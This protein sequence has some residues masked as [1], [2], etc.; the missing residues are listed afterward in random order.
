MKALITGIAGFAGSHL[1]EYLL[2]IG[3]EVS[4]IVRPGGRLDNISHLLGS[5]TLFPADVNDQE[6]VERAIMQSAP[7]YLFHLAAQSDVHRSWKEPLAT[8]LNNVAGQ[9]HLL[10]AIRL[11]RP[12]C[13][14]LIA[15]SSE[16]YG[17]VAPADVPIRESQPLRPVNPYAVSKTA[18]DLFGY[19]YYK[20]YGLHVVRIRTFHH[21]GPRRGDGF[22]TA[23]FA[24]Q[25]ADIE[26]GRQPP[27]LLVGNLDAERDFSDVRDVVRGYWLALEKGTAGEDY[28]IASGKGYTIRQMLEL[29]LDMTEADIEI[30]QD[31]ARLRPADVPSIVGDYAK[32]YRAT[33]WKPEIP[34]RQTLADL[35]NEWRSKP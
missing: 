3:I 15:C 8:M 35:L 9:I 2:G 12:G 20:G 24:K 21:T 11:H 23:S 33:G 1:A 16:E 13:R 18:Q 31:P 25:I 14:V 6:S 26:K 29:L 10:E 7:D 28:N 17:A 27:V 5:L 32:I 4:G 19:Q 22:V 34:F 30:R